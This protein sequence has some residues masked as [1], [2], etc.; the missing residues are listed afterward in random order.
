MILHGVYFGQHQ[1]H[2][3]R[4]RAVAI[5]N[6]SYGPLDNEYQLREAVDLMLAEVNAVQ[7]P[8]SRAL[9]LAVGI[10][11]IQ[12]FMDCNKRTGRV[13]AN[14]PLLQAGLP[15][16]SFVTMDKVGYITGLLAYYELGAGDR[17]RSTLAEACVA[18]AE[19]YR[20]RVGTPRSPAH[21]VAEL[22]YRGFL[23]ERVR[24]IVRDP[25][26]RTA[27]LPQTIPVEDRALVDELLQRQLD[28]LH[29]GRAAVIG[30]SPAEIEFFLRQR[31]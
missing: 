4:T 15:P 11:Y 20:S 30:V 16:V 29:A 28:T 27:R 10:A 12:P 5:G 3:I 7:D 26:A 24:A 22:K 9:M 6:S 2:R 8:W 25:A 13:M 14:L 19:A 21:E 23:R 17:I 1:I 18:S 31:K